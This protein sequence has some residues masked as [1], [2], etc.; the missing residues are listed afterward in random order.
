[1][2][3]TKIAQLYSDYATVWTVRVSFPS[4]AT[5]LSPSITSIPASS[6]GSHLDPFRLP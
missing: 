6:Q 4:R 3:N 2:I 1:M 5:E